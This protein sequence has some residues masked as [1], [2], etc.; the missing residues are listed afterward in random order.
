MAWMLDTAISIPLTRPTAGPVLLNVP[1]SW[2]SADIRKSMC[3]A[4]SALP[5]LRS[6]D[7]CAGAVRVEGLAA[8]VAAAG[9]FEPGADFMIAQAAGFAF[10]SPKAT[11]IDC[12][13]HRTQRAGEVRRTF[14]AFRGMQSLKGEHRSTAEGGNE[15]ELMG[16]IPMALQRAPTTRSAE[17][18]CQLLK[19]R[20]QLLGHLPLPP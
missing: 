13:P 17:E 18:L 9:I 10:R 5:R 15:G 19:N 11:S 7:H 6:L 4:S 20:G 2:V 3:V 14:V 1:G 12:P 16:Q 8:L